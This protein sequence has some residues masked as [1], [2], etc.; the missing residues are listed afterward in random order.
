MVS[1]NESTA[2]CNAVQAVDRLMA[3]FD[4]CFYTRFNTRLVRGGDEPVYLVASEQCDH[5]QV[6]FAHGYFSSALHEVAH[7]CIA[8]EARR[9]ME[10]Y[11][12]WYAPDGRT[13]EQQQAFEQVEIKPQALEWIFSVAAGT[14]F[15]ISADNLSAHRG[16]NEAFARAVFEQVLS[17]CKSG[18]PSRADD[19]RNALADCF[20]AAK[21]LDARSFRLD[22]LRL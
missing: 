3:V 6:V 4:Q 22:D 20:N 14:P 16:D 11:G 1:V 9:A 15:R 19:F 8:G 13:P 10:D 17:Y 5:H 18:L 7:W 12:Y 2:V 21:P